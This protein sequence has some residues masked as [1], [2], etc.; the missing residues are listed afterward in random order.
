[1]LDSERYRP[2]PENPRIRH[3]D[4]I[5]WHE[6]PLPRRFH[7]C[8]SQTQGWL[9]LIDFTRYCAC[10]ATKQSGSRWTG[11]NSRRT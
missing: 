8:R 5:P 2:D 11:R 7:R 3:L 6:A 9:T 1:M 4:G 10:G